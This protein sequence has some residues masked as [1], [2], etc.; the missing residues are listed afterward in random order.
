[1]KIVQCA[2]C[3]N[4]AF[5]L[6]DGGVPMVCCGE[7]MQTLEAGTTD[8]ALEKH[9]P[10]V[11]VEGNTM[12]V[13][14][15]SVAHP[16]T[17]EHYIMWILVEQGAK[18]QFVKLTPTDEPKATFIVEPG[19]YTVYEFCNLHGLWKVEGTI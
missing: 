9:V 5:I 17:P 19:A 7:E 15:G 14:V 3:G 16:M 10:A 2:H 13:Q 8:A 12:H 6:H 4:Q 18:V 11:K 1:M